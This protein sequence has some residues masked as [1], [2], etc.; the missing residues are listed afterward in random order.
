[1]ASLS[2]VSEIAINAT[3]SIKNITSTLDTAAYTAITIEL[4]TGQPIQVF[5]SNQDSSENQ[6]HAIEINGKKTNWTGPYLIQTIK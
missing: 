6:K 1:M 5:L 4:T 2:A 3:S